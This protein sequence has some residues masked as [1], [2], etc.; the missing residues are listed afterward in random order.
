MRTNNIKQKVKEYFLNNPTVK[1]RVRQI[2]KTLKI[3]L[4]SAIRYAKELTEEKILKTEKIS[5]IKL[6]TANTTSER[7][8]LEKKL[9]NIKQIYNSGLINYLIE[10]Y[11]NPAII[12]FGSY[13]KGED[14]ENSD[15]DM[16]VQT[17]SKKKPPLKKFEKILNRK[18]QIFSHKNIKGIS[19]PMLANNIING[20]ILNGFIEIF[21]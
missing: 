20:I 4:P 2:E 10:E 21:Q 3:P 15:I 12:L 5:N 16:Y 6:F 19:N 7:F 11:S 9:H 13:S 1:L 8:L 17:P 14:I 18:I